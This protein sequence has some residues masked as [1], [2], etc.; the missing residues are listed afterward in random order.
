M[1]QEVSLTT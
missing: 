1:P